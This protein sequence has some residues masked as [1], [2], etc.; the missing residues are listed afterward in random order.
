MP[1]NL[2]SA[3]RTSA[4]EAPEPAVAQTVELDIVDETP[5]AVEGEIPLEPLNQAPEPIVESETAVLRA[6]EPFDPPVEAEIPFEPESATPP[7]T[8]AEQT[9]EPTFEPQPVAEVVIEPV[10]TDVQEAIPPEPIVKPEPLA[11]NE[12]E[13]GPVGMSTVEPPVVSTVV[14]P[15]VSTVEPPGMSTVEPPVVSAVE[16]PELDIA[17]EIPL[18]ANIDVPAQTSSRVP[19]DAGRLGGLVEKVR[20]AAVMGIGVGLGFRRFD[21]AHRRR[22]DGTPS[23]WSGFGGANQWSI[24]DWNRC[25]FILEG[26]GGGN[27]R[28]G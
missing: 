24:G 18:D 13:S 12:I 28:S 26:R 14:P 22:F 9:P 25:G 15:V 23:G 6:V 27:C 20:V 3:L 19:I 11:T 1:G 16:P 2:F 8:V 17:D 10:A 5:P 4:A 21:R 7:Q